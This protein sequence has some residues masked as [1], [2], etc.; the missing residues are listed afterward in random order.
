[1][2]SIQKTRLPGVAHIIPIV[3]GKGG[4]GKTFI[5][6]NLALALAK[7]GKRVALF[8]ADLCT[9]GLPAMFGFRTKVAPTSDNRIIPPEVFGIKLLSMASLC[10]SDD[11]PIAWRGPIVSKLT[12]ELLKGALWGEIDVM[13]IDLPSSVND[14]SLEILQHVELS[15]AI[16][17]TTPQLR[18]IAVVKRMLR[19]LE[20]I[21]VPILGIIENMRG[22]SFGEGG[23]NR[24]AVEFRTQTLASIPLRKQFLMQADAGTPSFQKSEEAEM[25]FM[26]IA[27]AVEEKIGIQDQV[28]DVLE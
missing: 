22:E 19:L 16:V 13:L 11:E 20:L 27:R 18:A 14:A 25:M 26:K 9:P 17:I 15:G 1:M 8:D 2:S 10:G 21:Q 5:A 4:V 12:R 23:A 7:T 3:S 6:A 28:P 24:L